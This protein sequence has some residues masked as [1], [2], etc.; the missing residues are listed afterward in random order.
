MEKESCEIA[1]TRL[2]LEDTQQKLT[3]AKKELAEK[4]QELLSTKGELSLILSSLSWRI[5]KPVR[6]S[7]RLARG[8][9]SQV[10]F[11]LKKTPIPRLLYRIR[12]EVR[13]LLPQLSLIHSSRNDRVLIESAKYRAETLFCQPHSVDLT[14]DPKALPQ[15]DV[16][17]VTFNNT[18]WLDTFYS[19][20]LAQDYPLGLINIK[21]VDNGSNDE[22]VQA[23][24]YFKFKYKNL[25]NSIE[26]YSQTNKGY[27]AGHDAAIAKGKSEYILVTN[28]DLEFEQTA[29]LR[30]VSAAIN[31]SG[32]VASW[33]LRQKPYEHPKHYD[34]VSLDTLWS[35]HACVLMRRS[36]YEQVG[37]YEPRIFMYGEDV[38]LSY[39]F[40]SQGYRLKYVPSAVV[41]H[42]TYEEPGQV[43]PIQFS[44]S[45]LANIY[46]RLRYGAIQDWFG[47][48]LLYAGL[49]VKGGGF[50]GSRVIALKNWQSIMRNLAYF[51]SKSKMTNHTFPFRGFD[52]EMV[53]DGAFYRCEPQGEVLPLVTVVTRTY[54]GRQDWLKEC[55]CSVAN[56]TYPNVQHVIVEDGGDTMAGLIED[57]KKYY[58]DSCNVKYRTLPKKGRSFAGNMGL[59]LADGEYLMFLD[60]DDLLYADHV[61]VLMSALTKSDCAAAYSLSWEVLTDLNSSEQ[62]TQYTEREYHLPEVYRQEFSREKL[63]VR[64]YIPIQ[65]IIFKRKLYEELGGFDESMEYLEDW[66]LWVKYGLKYDFKFVEKTTSLYRVPF[67]LSER[68]KRKSLLDGA[69]FDALA[70]QEELVRKLES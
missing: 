40:R 17:V 6:F 64:N 18:H 25:F 2:E 14:L 3:F 62:G 31:D 43:K 61:E 45:T 33:E 67:S 70:K 59:S 36:A 57:I 51:C 53:R 1:A 42:Y 21:F 47:G 55:V 44:G 63:K 48:A 16:S 22:S 46:I 52:Y 56:Q 26:V 24:D 41:Y 29:I 27:G 39:R 8:D 35:S 28:I 66:H 23:L 68:D 19:S 49:V 13:R 20:L 15:I 30:V 12:A 58:G 11:L 54:K 10:V 37:G 65:S 34:P 38:E 7:G 4:K 50:N 60:D 32:M 69:Y 5:T 9:F